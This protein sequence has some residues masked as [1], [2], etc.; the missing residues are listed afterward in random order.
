MFCEN[1]G[2]KIQDGYKFCTKCGQPPVSFGVSSV[3]RNSAANPNEQW[4]HRL[5]KVA[6]IFLYLQIL[7]VVPVVWV[8]NST[9]YVYYGGKYQ[10]V[11]T[12]GAAF[13]STIFATMIF[14]VA[15]RLIKLTILYVALAQKP[16]WHKEFKK[17]F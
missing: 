7:W 6:Y 16:E 13:W 9:D 11:D 8:V 15:L 12:Y 3:K 4:W 10:D 14:I 2:N 5:I 17:F 1:C